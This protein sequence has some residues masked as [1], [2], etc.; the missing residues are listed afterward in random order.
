[1]QKTSSLDFLKKE[2][3]IPD[4]AIEFIKNANENTPCDKY[5]FSENC[6]AMVQ[7]YDSKITEYL[8]EEKSVRMEAH[9]IYTDVQ[10]LISGEEKILYA[11]IDGLNVLQEY[12]CEKDVMFYSCKKYNEVLYSSG[13]AVILPPKDAHAP[14]LAI[15]ISKPV[16]KIVLKVK[17]L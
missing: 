11:D 15:D 6:Y 2:L 4:S 13:E 10:Y 16:K 9:K 1:M 17:Q 14:G 5:V 8:D 7:A 3:N 12:I